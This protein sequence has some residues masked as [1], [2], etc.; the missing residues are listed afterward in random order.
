MRSLLCCSLI[1]GLVACSGEVSSPDLGEDDTASA[2]PDG[3]S[4]GGEAGGGTSDDGGSDSGGEGGGEDGGET[5]GEETGGDDTAEPEPLGDLREPGPYGVSRSTRSVAVASCTMDV[6]LYEPDGEGAVLV[7]LSHGFA[8]SASNLLGLG[9]H[10]ASWGL[11]VALPALCHS[12]ILDTDHAQNGADI[13]SLAA[14]LGS[15]EVIYAG[16]SAGGLASLLAGA[17]DAATL[18]VISLDGV[19]A[20]GLGSGAAGSLSAPLYGLVGE[21]SSCNSSNNG[22]A[23]FAAAPDAQALRVTEADHCDF[24]SDTD[25]LCT[26]FCTGSNDLFSDADLA[27]TITGLTTAAALEAAGLAAAAEVWWE[28]GGEEHDALEASGAITGL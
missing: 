21:S 19:D 12:S 8:R 1:S 3:G 9:E 10:L 23:W 13:V 20:S 4:E 25:E 22:T 15:S 5:A 16:Q 26:W 7:V 27:S 14:A 28:A 24:E 2:G 17:Q 11:T 18:G 6:V